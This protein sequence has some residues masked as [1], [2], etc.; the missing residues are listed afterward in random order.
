M[1]A[2]ENTRSGIS[3][4]SMIHNGGTPKVEVDPETYIVKADGEVLVCEPA[5]EFAMAQRYFM[6]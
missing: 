5:K 6:Y 4:A 2:V 3:K 1:V